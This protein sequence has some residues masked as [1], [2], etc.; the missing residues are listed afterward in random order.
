VENDKGDQPRW[1]IPD[2]LN[3]FCVFCGGKPA[4]KTSEHIVPQW[5]IRL[6]G[7]EN[8]KICVGV[9]KKTGKQISLSAM[10]NVF[11]AC[12]DCNNHYASLEAT[13]QKTI[14]N[15]LERQPITESE[16]SSLL[17]WFDKVRVGLWLGDMMRNPSHTFVRRKFHITQRIGQ[18]DRCL[19]IARAET[20]SKKFHFWGT[21]Q[22]IFHFMPSCF[23]LVI[24]GL[25]FINISLSLWFGH[26]L[27]LATLGDRWED[28]ITG[29]IHGDIIPG[30]NRIRL[31]LVKI[32]IPTCFFPIF[33]PCFEN[34]FANDTEF[35]NSISDEWSRKMMLQN[36]AKGKIVNIAGRPIFADVI[37]SSSLNS[38][39]ESRK[40][41]LNYITLKT[42]LLTQVELM[43]CTP[44][45]DH[46]SKDRREFV[47][48][49]FKKTASVNKKVLQDLEQ[50][51]RLAD[52]TRGF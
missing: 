8:R 31:P 19:L 28:E 13:A 47:N 50:Q 21:I 32:D 18:N 14:I 36:A 44:S 52:F 29:H 26:R 43:K 6:T 20:S 23:A 9:N 2:Q 49:I 45:R 24:N 38:I 3:R 42:V 1:G 11:P 25:Y 30:K 22:P 41:F 17:D 4:E 7:Q 10:S 48:T 15:L 40:E 34:T 27:G 5:L 51:V 46:W 37:G 16:C 33:Q 35:V 12:R 39:S